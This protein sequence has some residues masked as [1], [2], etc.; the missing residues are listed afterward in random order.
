MQMGV[1]LTQDVVK[2]RN[3][4]QGQ[5]GV[6]WVSAILPPFLAPESQEAGKQNRR[7]LGGTRPES[8]F[9]GGGDG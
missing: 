9:L 5:V 4:I 3:H 2:K 1:W 8:A 6:A 7:P